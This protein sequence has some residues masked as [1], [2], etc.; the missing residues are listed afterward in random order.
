MPEKPPRYKDADVR[1]ALQPGSALRSPYFPDLIE[2]EQ[3]FFVDSYDSPARRTRIRGIFY[4]CCPALPARLHNV[5]G[6]IVARFAKGNG[7]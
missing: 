6:G 1:K 2:R 4:L 7:P 5:E 3:L